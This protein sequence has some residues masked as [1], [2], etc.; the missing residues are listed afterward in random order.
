M[1]TFDNHSAPVFLQESDLSK[2]AIP[3]YRR[4]L[5]VL[6]TGLVIAFT[7][8]VLIPLAAVVYSVSKKGI[9]Q[10]KFP[11]VFTELPPPPGLT[12][13]GF[14]HAIIG[15]LMT[16]SVATVIAVPFG[17]LAAIYL[18]EF[19]KGT[20]IAQI[21]KFSC[22]VLTGVPA[23]LCGLF[24]YSIVVLPMRSFSAFS[25]GVAT[26]VL[27]LPIIVRAAEEALLLVP[28]EMRQASIGIGATRFQT[29]TQIVIPTAM[30]ALTTGIVLALGRAAGE[31]APLLFTAFNNNFW[32][33]DLFQPVA[34]LP[35]LIYFFSIIPYKASQDLAWA[36][37]MMLVFIVLI[38]S[39]AA[40]FFSRQKVV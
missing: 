35:V 20:K 23:I 33:N 9:N 14:G 4:A 32:S 2:S 6:L 13:G 15:T 12:E 24:A 11:T 25:G 8:S 3:L 29:I 16:L 10:L 40:R 5:S 31:A 19:G 37:A 30:P 28:S 21:V 7:A 17:V 36:A 39:I 27:M 26:G 18:A 38:F 22:N 34:T 1:D